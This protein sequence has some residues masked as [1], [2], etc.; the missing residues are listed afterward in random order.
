MAAEALRC[1]HVNGICENQPITWIK[2]EHKA[3]GWYECSDPTCVICGITHYH[4]K[5]EFD[6]S[7]K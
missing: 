1:D 6:S 7:G 3:Q 4:Q 2:E 5:P